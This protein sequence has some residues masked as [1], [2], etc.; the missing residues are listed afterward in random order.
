[1]RPG[2]KESL[3]Y[4]GRP[5][6]SLDE[7]EGILELIN[8]CGN[9][10]DR[11]KGLGRLSASLFLT[12]GSPPDCHCPLPSMS[13][14]TGSPETHLNSSKQPRLSSPFPFQFLQAF[15]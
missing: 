2:H 14:Q 4:F 9:G 1:M 5:Q 15:L 3:S 6:W 8:L 12:S 11:I 7:A 10:R 13:L